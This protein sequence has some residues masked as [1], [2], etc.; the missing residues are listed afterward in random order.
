MNSTNN[1]LNK[2]KR[3][4]TNNLF[5]F[6]SLRHLLYFPFAFL[7]QYVVSAAVYVN[8]SDG[9]PLFGSFVQAPTG[10]YISQFLGIPFAEPPIGKLRF[11]R[12][13]PKRPWREQWN[14]TYFRDSCVQSP[15]T[16]FGNFYGATMWNS[17]TPCSED[18]LYLN[19]YV[20]GEIDPEKRLPVLFWIYGGGFWSGTASLDV[21]DGKIFAGEE[22]VI[23][24]TVN[25]RVTV[26]GFLYLGREEAPGNVG[27]WD[28]LLALKWIYKNIQTFGG[29]PSLITL[30]GESAGAASVSM[31]LL[32]PH[33]QPYFTRSIL[34]S[35]S[36]TAPWA[37]ENKQ[38]ALHRAVI[39]YEYMKCGNNNIS[40]LTPDQWNMDEVLKCLINASADKLRDAEWSPVMEFAD[41]PW[42][43]V[44][45]GE[46]LVEN[47]ET[48]LKQ[49]H[50]KKTQL[51]VGSNFDEAIYFIVYQLADV[52]PPNEFFEKKEFIKSREVWLK[53]V[54]SLLPRQIL[55]SSIA[56]QAI[57]NHYEPEGLPIESKQWVDSLDKM[58]GDFLFTCNVNDFALAFSEHGVNTYYYMFSHRASQQTWP[59]WM[60]V[61]HG[62]EINFIFGEP[63]NRKQFKY[64]KEEQELSSRF[65]RF[66]ANFARTGDPNHNSDNSY[67]SDWPLY[68]SKTMEYINLTIES[69]YIQ[70]GSKRLGTGPRRKHCNFWKF[71]S[72]LISISADLGESF[73]KWKQQMD[74]WEN[75]Y[76]TDWE[77]H[78]EQY[79]RHQIYRRKDQNDE[80]EIK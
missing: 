18:C 15:D 58:L 1:K 3:I 5:C 66:W 48:S 31:H 21:Y 68:N 20:P 47:I 29:D 69:D 70:K 42:V 72:K 28:Q 24:V 37:L 6:I 13:I 63:Y 10:K 32:S 73:I 49:G 30:F 40:H 44:I 62:Y 16:Y 53:S 25:Y 14:S 26:F 43:P 57:L 60:G 52:F 12:P 56:L 27:L 74:R 59:A 64:T 55:K 7:S 19:I 41:F 9:S 79:K 4:K 51:L 78:F 23:I 80:C 2:N 22:N 65:M 46:F 71:I 61:L 38:V 50:F 17:N 54:S 35:G 36:A 39:L 67:N 11:R 75:D 34:Q 76:M 77:N 45:D 8:L 33:S